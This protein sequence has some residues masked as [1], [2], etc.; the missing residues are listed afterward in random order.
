MP[1]RFRFDPASR[2]G[3]VGVLVE[4]G[5]VGGQVAFR[6]SHLVN[7]SCSKLPQTHERVRGEGGRIVVVWGSG[8]VGG[9]VLEVHVPSAC[10]KDLV[11]FSHEL[12]W[13]DFQSQRGGGGAWRTRGTRVRPSCN[14]RVRSACGSTRR[15][16][17][18]G[19]E[20]TFVRQLRGR[21]TEESPLVRCLDEPLA[22]NL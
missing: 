15:C 1:E 7:P 6:R 10:S 14:G 8:C 16:F 20:G 21:Y 11:G 19:G 13:G 3:S 9:P 2:A 4:P 12:G 17:L 22:L 18:S 5:G